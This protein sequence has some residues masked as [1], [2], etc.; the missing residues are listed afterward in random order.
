MKKDSTSTLNLVI[1][2]VRF[3]KNLQK[4]STL[5]FKEGRGWGG[6]LKTINFSEFHPVF[7]SPERRA[8]YIYFHCSY[9]YDYYNSSPT[10]CI[11]C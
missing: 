4:K 9:M 11:K 8:C 3:R 6:T 7:F 10:L 2:R 1:N 5:A